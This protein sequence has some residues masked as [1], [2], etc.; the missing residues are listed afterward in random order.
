M[1]PTYRPI[2][3]AEIPAFADLEARTYRQPAERYLASLRGEDSRFDWRDVRGLWS[4]EGEPVAALIT[5]HRGVSFGGGELTAGL[6]G[7]VAVPPEQRRRGYGR[8][9]LVHL[10][11][12]LYALQTPISLLFPFSV[13]WYRTLGYG[14]ANTNC[15]LEFPPALLPAYPERRG[16]R[17]AGPDDEAAVHRCYDRARALPH[18]NGWL[19]RTDWEWHHRV[20]KPEHEMV[21]YEGQEGVE[22]YLVYTLS[23][24]I[25]RAPLKVAEWVWTT[26]AAWRGLAGFLAALGE[27]VTSITY[28]APAHSPLLAAMPE[29]Y[30]RTGTATEFVFWPVAR[31]VS[32]FMLRLVHL[33]AALRQRPYPARVAADLVLAVADGQHPQNQRPLHLHIAGG[34]AHVVELAAG[35][36]SGPGVVETDIATLGEIYAGALPAEQART[37]GR[38]R[39]DDATCAQLT[40]AFA[41]APFFMQPADWF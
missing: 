11:Q 39:A 41:A 8:T 18:N 12:E 22:G 5:L 6:V 3:E 23:W 15:F 20:G 21:V 9:L 2:A 17:R 28:N 25:D 27:Q 34:Q 26:D 10:L 13:A 38:L 4:G 32:G 33:P 29:P 30:D 24:S 37:A 1:S 40:A 16:V 36:R 7:G 19:A 35:T 31:L 14:L